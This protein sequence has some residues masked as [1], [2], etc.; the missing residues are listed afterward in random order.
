MRKSLLASVTMLFAGLFI[1]GSVRTTLAQ[2]SEVEQA[3][4]QKPEVE[5][6]EVQKPEVEK[7]EVQKPEGLKH[8][9][10]RGRK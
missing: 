4:V 2:G 3:E 10:N 7:V 8:G 6:A 5:K 1:L 9:A